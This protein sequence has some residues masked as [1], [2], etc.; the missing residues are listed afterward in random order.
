MHSHVGS[1][2]A[3]IYS[4]ALLIQCIVLQLLWR[5]FFQDASRH[6]SQITTNRLRCIRRYREIP[7]KTNRFIVKSNGKYLAK[8]K[9]AMNLNDLV[10]N[11]S[12]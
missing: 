3:G 12:F 1:I 10:F 7:A 8:K 4:I 11:Y 6:P 2:N 5:L 9:L